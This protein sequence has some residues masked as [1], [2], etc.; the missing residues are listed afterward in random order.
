MLKGSF[1][2]LYTEIMTNWIKLDIFQ[3]SETIFK[4]KNQLNLLKNDFLLR[5]SNWENNI[6]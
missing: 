2:V 4:V 6:Y 3:F 1:D 5:I